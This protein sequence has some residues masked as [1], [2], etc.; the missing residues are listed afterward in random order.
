M[1]Q[2]LAGQEGDQQTRRL[3]WQMIKKGLFPARIP[4]SPY[5]LNCRK[6]VIDARLRYRA[7]AKRAR[8]RVDP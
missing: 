6:D 2:V 3:R 1:L 7:D 8:G 4:L 5:R